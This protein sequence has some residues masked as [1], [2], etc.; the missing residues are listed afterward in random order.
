MI[1]CSATA[2]RE[3]RGV[4]LI[5]SGNTRSI[6]GNSEP[7][8][9]SCPAASARKHTINSLRM[10]DRFL[11]AK[12]FIIPLFLWSYQFY[13]QIS[14]TLRPHGTKYCVSPSTHTRPVSKEVT[15]L[16]SSVAAPARPLQPD[17]GSHNASPFRLANDCCSEETSDG[18]IQNRYI[19]IIIRINIAASINYERVAYSP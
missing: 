19:K 4:C 18:L 6:R 8:R 15:G 7:G 2:C 9:S 14:C 17:W 11:S 5:K 12:R 13:R 16:L 1:E 3:G 10:I